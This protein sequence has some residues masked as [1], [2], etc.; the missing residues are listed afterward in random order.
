MAHDPQLLNRIYNDPRLEEPRRLAGGYRARRTDKL[1]PSYWTILT[2]VKEQARDDGDVILASACWCFEQIG[3]AQDHFTSAFVQAQADE[4]Y[5]SW[6]ELDRA[7]I[8]LHFLKEH[9]PI[10]DD[11]FGLKH[12]SVHVP[13]F[14]A[15]F[16][17]KVFLSPGM[18][19]KKAHCSICQAAIKLRGG[20]GHVIGQIYEGKMCSRLITEVEL[21]EISLVDTPVQKYSVP[22]GPDITYDYGAIRYVVAG[23]RSPWHG[24][25]YTESETVTHNEGF[26]GTPRNAICPCGS[27][28]K[29]KRCCKREKRKKVHYD[30][31]FEYRPPAD[32]PHYLDDASFRVS[33]APEWMSRSTAEA[34][35]P[36]APA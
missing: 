6:C 36:P 7:E 32:L 31:Q 28:K 5:R 22:F 8:E 17:Y 2:E 20:C 12:I 16:P 18:V 26:P 19:V 4:F 21:L 14:Q 1:P 23:L 30:V 3:R 33:G 9:L 29:Y 10:D 13:R 27:G 25:N 24:W 11:V 34:A 15:L 35:T